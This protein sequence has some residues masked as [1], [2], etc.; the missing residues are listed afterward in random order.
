MGAYLVR[1]RIHLENEFLLG[2]EIMVRVCHGLGQA[3]CA[4]AEESGRSRRLRPVLIVK[5]HPVR[6]AMV[7]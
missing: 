3:R 4:A 5:G 6:L 1:P 2:D 7:E